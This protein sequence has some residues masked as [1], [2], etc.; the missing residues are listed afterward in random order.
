MKGVFIAFDQAHKDAV[1]NALTRLNCRGFSFFEQMQGRG[2]NT[3]EPHYG[4][5]AWASM[6]SG[7]ITMVE[8]NIVEKLLAALK[9]ID[10]SAEM[11]GLRAFVWNIEQCY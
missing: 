3:G 10:E 11:L 6:N 7:I 2:S 1:I 4:T 9:E 8:D 5:H